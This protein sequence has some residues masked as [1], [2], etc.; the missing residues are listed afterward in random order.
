MWASPLP[1]TFTFHLLSRRCR[2]CTREL[3]DLPLC[4]SV[5]MI[6]QIY[7]G[8]DAIWKPGLGMERCM[9]GHVSGWAPALAVPRDANE[10]SS[11]TRTTAA[12]P[13]PWDHLCWQT[14]TFTVV[15][16]GVTVPEF[17]GHRTRQNLLKSRRLSLGDC[18]SS[19]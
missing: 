10:A 3:N 4:L 19:R 6:D 16:I 8:K 1:A 15:F 7:P 13:F 14:Q 2:A 5:L 17:H 12:F 18:Q 9:M 11:A